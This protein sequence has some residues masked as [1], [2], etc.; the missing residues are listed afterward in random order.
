MSWGP[1]V[2]NPWVAGRNRHGT[3]CPSHTER[4]LPR[5][6]DP[7][8]RTCVVSQPAE[9]RSTPVVSGWSLRR[10]EGS[11]SPVASCARQRNPLPRPPG[12]RV[13]V[14]AVAGGL[15]AVGSATTTAVCRGRRPSRARRSTPESCRGPSASRSSGPTAIACYVG[16][17]GDSSA[18]GGSVD[19]AVWRHPRPRRKGAAQRGRGSAHSRATPSPRPERAPRARPRPPNPRGVGPVSR[20]ARRQGWDGPRAL[21]G[22]RQSTPRRFALRAAGSAAILPSLKG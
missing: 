5:F 16:A 15:L 8:H 7:V 17:R 9:S 10:P 19:P 3:V 6:V 21:W 18:A 22:A 13:R 11:N 2:P 20:A 14:P 4:F 1:A 12:P